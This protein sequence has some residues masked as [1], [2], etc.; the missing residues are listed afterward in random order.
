MQSPP[1]GYEIRM[2]RFVEAADLCPA[3]P[4]AFGR[5]TLLTPAT[6]EAWRA[7]Q[8]AAARA[9]GVELLLLSGFRSIERQTQIV[10]K[11]L[12]AGISLD[13]IL[14]VNAYPGHSE[15]HTGRAIDIGSPDCEHLT[16]AFE[17]TKEYAWLAAHAAGFGF[18]LSYPR[19]NQHGIAFEPW[20]WY[21]I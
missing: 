20:H 12:E 16:E 21:K 1:P 18:S 5:E 7:M 15:H 14:K 10:Q 8:Q 2:P 4:D 3:G 19:A 13:E 6:A 9:E 11:K 17:T